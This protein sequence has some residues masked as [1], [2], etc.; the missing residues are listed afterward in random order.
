MAE[1]KYRLVTRADFDGV[2]CGTLLKELGLIDDTLFAEPADMQA[3]RIGV[4]ARDITANLPFVDG[5]HL[6]FDHHVSELDRVG[7]Q[8]NLVIDPDSPSTARVIYRHYGGKSGF[9]EIS[10]ELMAAVDQ[11]D[12]AQFSEEDILAPTGWTLLNFL[13]DP[14]TG[15]S[16]NKEFSVPD[17]QFFV[18]LMTYC[19]HN[20]IDEIMQLP[21]VLERVGAYSYDSE[22]AEMQ[23]QRCTKTEGITV[24]TDL[25]GEE[26]L[27]PVNRFLVYA[28]Y[29]DS[30]ISIRVE[31]RHDGQVRIAA[32]KS[33]LNRTARANIGSMMLRFGGGGH[34]AAGACRVDADKVDETIAELVKGI[35]D[36]ES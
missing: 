30:K 27:V 3:G 26:E 16:R 14:A 28:L 15:L 11:S 29:P 20:P 12:S 31:N 35:N 6:C 21:D 10:D 13:V 23:Y 22:F 33:V 34:A 8:E 25:R 2:V 24:V 5:V 36:A 4:E 19:R 7:E 32:G 18:D 1:A 9:P 17:D